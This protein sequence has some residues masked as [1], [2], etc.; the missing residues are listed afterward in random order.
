MSLSHVTPPRLTDTARAPHLR[1]VTAAPASA[2]AIP[3]F[4]PNIGDAEIAAVT[5]VMRS[6]WMTTGPKTRAFEEQFAAFIGDGIHAVAVN[7]ATVGLHLAAEAIGIGPGDE[8]L[9]P[10]LT[11]TATAAAVRYLG[12]EARLVDVDPVTYTID[13]EH[14]A[15]RLTKRTK[16]IMP[17]HFG[18]YPCDMPAILDFA[19]KH[20]LRVIEDAAHALPAHCCGRMVGS[21]GSDATVF[22]FYASKT[23]T[24]G[25]GGM[26]VTADPAVAA[27]ARVMRTHGLDR[28]AFDR[29]RKVGAS[30]AYDVVAPGYKYNMTD[31]A[32]AIGI[33]QLGRANDLQSQ[34]QRAALRY[35]E[36]LRGLPLDLPA[37][38]PERG[39]HS[40]HLFPV[41]VH[42]DAGC[43]RDGLIERLGNAGIGTSVHYRP[44]HQM[45]YWQQRYPDDRGK[46]PVS[47]RYFAGALTLPLFAGLSDADVDRVVSEVSHAIGR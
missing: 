5:E 21:W 43:T 2:A 45:T 17:V 19:Y 20:G 47:D 13:L 9:I 25:E 24:T 33:V 40:W 29:F 26:L 14:A 11:F 37:A 46:F 12:G 31:M 18:G 27:R 39:L 32:S 38:A 7:S 3:V 16:A 34:R 30:W 23:I 44:L 10:T 15:S 35:L 8:V 28:D 42:P 22:S 1:S 36:Q 4:K 6:G 41:V